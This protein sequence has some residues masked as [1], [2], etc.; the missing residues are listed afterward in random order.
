MSITLY[1]CYDARSLRPLWTLEEL[2]LTYELVNMEFPPRY[3]H[4]DYRDINPLGTVPAMII[5]GITMTESSAIAA[6]LVEK[7]APTDLGLTF[8][9]PDYPLYLNWLYRSDAT[10]TFPLTV[11]LRY[12]YLEPGDAGKAMI[13]DDY[14]KWFLNRAQSIE[15]ALADRDYLVADRF[16]VVDICVGYAAI[17]AK[18]LRMAEQIGPRTLA[19]IDRITAR[20]SF[21]RVMDK[22]AE[23]LA[24]QPEFAAIF[25]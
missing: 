6:Y 21:K 1:H 7:Y 20:E 11:V 2:G 10:L 3:K 12:R 22:Q 4:P 24:R 13:A 8:S 17:L 14:E 15:D 23:L 16:T 5:D 19:Y 18:K 25:G 9:H